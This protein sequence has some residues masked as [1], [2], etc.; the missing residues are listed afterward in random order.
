[1]KKTT[2]TFLISA[3][4]ALGGLKAQSVQEGMNHLYADRFK[5]AEDVFQKLLAT[6]PNNIDATYWLGQTYLDEDQNAKAEELYDKALQT[7]ANA[8]LLLVGKGHVEL[9][10]KKTDEARQHFEA[11]LTM[12]RTKKGDDPVIL[13]AIG[14]ANVDAKAGDVQYAVDKLEASVLRDPKNTE[15]Y[16]QLGNAYRKLRPGEGGGPAFLNY[17]KALEVNPN[18]AVA[19]LRLA[20][21]FESQKN[22]DLVLQYLNDATHQDPKFAPAYYELFY[23]YF[24]HDLNFTEAENQLK[25]YIDSRQPF[26]YIEDEYLYAQLCFVRKDLDCAITK[27]NNVLTTMGDQAK[28]KVKKLLADAYFRKGD[29]ANAKKYID[30]YLA[31]EKQESIISFDVKLKADIYSKLGANCDELYNIYMAGAALDT[32]PQSRIDYLSVAADTFKLRS[33]KKQEADT[34]LVIYKTRLKPQP[35]GLINIGILY[36]QCGELNKADSLFKAYTDVMPDSVYGYVWRGRVNFT[37][38]TTMLVE[39]FVTNMVTSFQKALDIA[40]TDKARMK[41]Q[42]INA[43]ITLAG[44]FYNI[45][46]DKE[47]ALMYTRKGLEFDSTNG[48][49]K[50]I[51]PVLLAPTK[52]PSPRGNAMPQAAQQAGSPADKPAASKP[53]TTIAP[54]GVKK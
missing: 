11:A 21:L 20:K 2:I 39:P 52:N 34:R 44:Y 9:L 31:R 25:K 29:Y 19:S 36:T 30:E 7:S 38:D 32:V 26:T 27:A 46:K 8:P 28:P 41:S 35:G 45:K 43:S 22:W 3:L 48:T 53:K 24:L 10:N 4:M 23:F 42:G 6:N 14:R 5:S 51:L 17:K 15:T 16:L 12:T 37:M 13:T 1:M 50:S 18:F 47:T 49:L 54:K 40:Y 33:C